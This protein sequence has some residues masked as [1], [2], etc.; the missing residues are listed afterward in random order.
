MR[1]YSI[2]CFIVIL[3]NVFF[4]FFNCE[5]WNLN[6]VGM[7]KVGCPPCILSAPPRLYLLLSVFLACFHFPLSVLF[8]TVFTHASGLHF[9]VPPF[10]SYKQHEIGNNHCL[11]YFWRSEFSPVSCSLSQAGCGK[12]SL[13]NW[14]QQNYAVESVVPGSETNPGDLLF[15]AWVTDGFTWKEMIL[16]CFS[17]TSVFTAYFKRSLK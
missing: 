11:L 14:L 16:G 6:S 13:E 9:L 15:I 12:S 5:C 3:L 4:F 8:A 10:S 17:C 7:E 1:F 2:W